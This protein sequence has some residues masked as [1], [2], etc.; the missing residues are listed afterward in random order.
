MISAD[1]AETSLA[2]LLYK[3]HVNIVVQTKAVVYYETKLSDIR[4]HS[5]RNEF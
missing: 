4:I 3:Y 5:S 2:S 1:T